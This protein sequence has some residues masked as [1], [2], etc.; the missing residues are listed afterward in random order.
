MPRS[1]TSRGDSRIES[2]ASQNASESSPKEGS[3]RDEEQQ[4]QAKFDQPYSNPAY[5]EHAAVVG[6]DFG[7]A[8]D[9]PPPSNPPPTVPYHR[10][11]LTSISQNCIENAPE[12]VKGSTTATVEHECCILTPPLVA[13]IVKHSSSINTNSIRRFPQSLCLQYQYVLLC[14]KWLEYSNHN[15]SKAIPYYCTTALY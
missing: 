2:V 13:V 11:S 4:E 1:V 9:D 10:L 12:R 5:S 3:F 6:G 7:S 8:L 15:Y 14:A